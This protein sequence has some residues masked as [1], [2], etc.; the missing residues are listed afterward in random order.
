LRPPGRRLHLLVFVISLVVGALLAS[1]PA[2]AQ[3]N[4]PDERLVILG[5]VTE[6]DGTPLADLQVVLEA[7]HRT[8]DFRTLGKVSRDETRR[9]TK[10]DESGNYNLRWFWNPYFNHV[11][12]LIRMTV[13]VPD[14]EQFYTLER[15]SLSDL[16]EGGGVV[17][18][19]VVVDDTSSLKRF[20]S[21]V[22]GLGTDDERRV[23]ERMGIPAKV[24]RMKLATHEEVTWWYFEAGRAYRFR[25]GR[26]ME[27]SEFEPVA[28]FGEESETEQ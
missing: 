10:T 13:R 9:T 18:V 15:R 24:D 17:R 5:V 16:A 2:E 8:F 22:S 27:T 11:E 1:T 4:V 7:S 28:P 6:S 26:L 23:Y 3:S 19:D 12:L 25:S 21:F 20:R 14:G